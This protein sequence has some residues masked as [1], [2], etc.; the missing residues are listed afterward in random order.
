MALIYIWSCYGFLLIFVLLWL[1]VMFNFIM[2]LLI[3]DVTETIVFICNWW[4]HRSTRSLIWTG[5]SM[6]TP[7]LQIQ[8]PKLQ[9]RTWW[10]ESAAN[11]RCQSSTIW[12]KQRF[13]VSL[14]CCVVWVI[15][16][17]SDELEVDGWMSGKDDLEG[18]GEDTFIL[19]GKSGV[20]INWYCGLMSRNNAR[21]LQVL[22]SLDYCFLF[23]HLNEL[24]SIMLCVT[25]CIL[26]WYLCHVW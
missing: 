7:W 12:M 15:F 26:L 19:K 10:A 25:F 21:M 6:W 4:Y 23:P 14:W 20:H 11:W 16:L 17:V 13:Q 8:T 5:G 1:W 9:P 2:F 3:V 22:S 24:I 18:V